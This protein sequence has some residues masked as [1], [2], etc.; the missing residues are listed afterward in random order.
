MNTLNYYNFPH[1]GHNINITGVSQCLENPYVLQMQ[2]KDHDNMQS[3][4]VLVAK[5]HHQFID[6]L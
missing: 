4:T 5:Y 6:E 1:V 3:I 2:E